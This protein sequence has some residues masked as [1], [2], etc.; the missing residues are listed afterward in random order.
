LGTFPHSAES[1]HTKRA[2]EPRWFPIVS[3]ETTQSAPRRASTAQRPKQTSYDASA[4]PRLDYVLR[5]TILATLTAVGNP[6]QRGPS[7][8][9]GLDACHCR[10]TGRR[11]DQ[12]LFSPNDSF[13]PLM[14][15]RAI[16]KDAG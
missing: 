14:M 15:I 6:C 12:G 5:L 1:M 10:A 3:A 9:G 8:V 13:F 2:A 4:I 11:E 7:S 16:R